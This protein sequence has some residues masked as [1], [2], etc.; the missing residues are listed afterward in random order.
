MRL[1]GVFG[2]TRRGGFSST[3]ELGDFSAGWALLARSSGLAVASSPARRGAQGLHI[4]TCYWSL[5]HRPLPGS[6]SGGNR[7]QNTSGK[8]VSQE[9]TLPGKQVSAHWPRDTIF[10]NFY[11]E[12]NVD[13]HALEK[14]NT[15]GS[16]GPFTQSNISARMPV[17]QHL[18]GRLTLCNEPIAA[19]TGF[20]SLVCMFRFMH[21]YPTWR[22]V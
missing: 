11:S 16:P 4:S 9:P 21:L 19:F 13:F 10:K 7:G 1:K 14:N 17:G 15:E 20:L 22:T 3:Q 8:L 2:Q 6:A 12:I 5:P 18:R